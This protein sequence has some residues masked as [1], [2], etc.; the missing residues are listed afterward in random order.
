MLVAT[1][2]LYDILLIKQ[3]I[4][5]KTLAF[6]Y[7]VYILVKNFA[8]RSIT[9]ATSSFDKHFVINDPKAVDLFNG[10]SNTFSFT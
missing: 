6:P 5:N 4:I 2:Y 10:K 3:L 9:M 7:T 8:L 1:S